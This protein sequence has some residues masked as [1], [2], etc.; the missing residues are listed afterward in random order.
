KVRYGQRWIAAF[1][2]GELWGLPDELKPG[3]EGWEAE[4]DQEPD[5]IGDYIQM[6]MAC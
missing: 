4:L 1:W 6:P 2:C 5:E 3:E